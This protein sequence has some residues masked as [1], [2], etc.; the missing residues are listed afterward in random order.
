MKALLVGS[1]KEAI[2]SE[3]LFQ[4]YTQKEEMNMLVHD[5]RETE[6]FFGPADESDMYNWSQFLIENSDDLEK[7]TKDV[8]KVE[9]EAL[10]KANEA[11]GILPVMKLKQRK[12]LVV[13]G[14]EGKLNVT[15]VILETLIYLLI[16]IIIFIFIF[17]IFF[18]FMRCPSRREG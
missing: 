10:Q 5:F 6:A 1:T 8:R 11:A 18:H 15:T 17:L 4:I 16:S 3:R 7:Y 14:D 13:T 12:L 9:A 2:K